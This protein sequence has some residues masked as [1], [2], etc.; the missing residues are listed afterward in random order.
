[1]SSR[2]PVSL[3][4]IFRSEAQYR[5]LGELFTHP[6]RELTIGELP[7][8]VEASHAT[9]S[10]EVARLRGGRPLLQSGTRGVDVW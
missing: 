10:R 2:G 3:L 4:P 5:L 6:G 7:R 8:L 1:M 9:V